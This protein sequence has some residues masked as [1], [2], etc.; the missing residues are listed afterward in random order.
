[1]PN[2]ILVTLWFRASLINSLTPNVVVIKG[3]RSSVRIKSNP[4]AAAISIIA[5]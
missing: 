2:I 1:M 3:L 4:E 5:T